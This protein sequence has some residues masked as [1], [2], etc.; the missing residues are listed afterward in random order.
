[1]QD[2]QFLALFKRKFGTIVLI[3]VLVAALSFLFL[4]VSQKN[5]KVST[6]FLVI[7]N[8]TS[9]QDY[10]SLSKS[11][12]YIGSILSESIRSEAFINEV[13]KTGKMDDEFL[14]FDK[15]KKLDEWNKIVQVKRSSQLA[16]L[17]IDVLGNNQNNTLKLSEG[18]IEVLIEK[19]NLFRGQDQNI[20]IRILSGPIIEKNPSLVNIIATVV[21]GFFV[22][23]L[24]SFIW[25]Y[26]KI[27]ARETALEMPQYSENIYSEN[28]SANRNEPTE[29][30][31][32]ESLRD[33]DR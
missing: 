13:I 9:G 11:A 15:K 23:C 6:D 27:S 21:A 5:F 25:F 18:I 17:S 14:P 12:E 4:V 24:L 30:E 31:Y 20:E 22:G 1:M 32:Q 10:Y 33:L 2:N 3:G 19:N 16:I 7:Q 28:F 26:Y 8:Q 29:E